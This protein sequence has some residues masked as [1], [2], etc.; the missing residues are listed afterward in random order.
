[1]SCF[2]ARFGNFRPVTSHLTDRVAL[3]VNVERGAI[4]HRAPS[5]DLLHDAATLDRLIGLKI[6]SQPSS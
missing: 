1:M 2:V 3:G 4:V 5:R 6:D